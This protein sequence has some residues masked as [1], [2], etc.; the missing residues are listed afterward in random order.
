MKVNFRTFVTA[1][2]MLVMFVSSS[3]MALTFNSQE[4]LS[5]AV[6]VVQDVKGNS[7]SMPV[8]KAW[9]S[10]L[11]DLAFYNEGLRT[12]EYQARTGISELNY[13]QSILQGLPQSFWGS[14]VDW[15]NPAYAV[16]AYRY[17]VEVMGFDPNQVGVMMSQD[18]FGVNSYKPRNFRLYFPAIKVANNVV[19]F[20]D[21]DY[22]D[23][24]GVPPNAM[25]HSQ[26]VNSKETLQASKLR[27]YSPWAVA[28]DEKVV[29]EKVVMTIVATTDCGCDHD[30]SGK[31]G[32]ST[33]GEGKGTNNVSNNKEKCKEKLKK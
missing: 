26:F 13:M 18:G 1:V 6:Q 31:V 2:A 29:T 28:S 19:V 16:K 15:R 30:N 4:I 21:R 8:V 14:Y 12:P 11:A 3:A 22:L 25:H 27:E 7:C 32:R 10:N 24:V 5:P 33:E 20:L 17:L 9:K 23:S